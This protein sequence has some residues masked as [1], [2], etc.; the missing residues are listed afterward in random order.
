MKYYALIFILIGCFCLQ[1]CSKDATQASSQQPQQNFGKPQMVPM[2]STAPP[3]PATDGKTVVGLHEFLKN[4]GWKF[5]DA[6]QSSVRMYKAEESYQCR[7]ERTIGY[8]ILRYENAA[9][10]QEEFSRIDTHYRNKF[11]RAVMANNFIIGVWGRQMGINHPEF[12]Q[13]SD[14]EYNKL[15]KDL[16]EF[17]S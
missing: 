13:L 10:A 16:A 6:N 3:K 14:V 17:A 9:K 12:I 1:G 8:L 11:G 2:R 4:K 7:D 15:Q 5:N